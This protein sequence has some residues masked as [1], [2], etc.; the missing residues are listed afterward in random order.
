MLAE[1]GVSESHFKKYFPVGGGDPTPD[2]LIDRCTFFIITSC[3]VATFQGHLSHPLFGWNP[4]LKNLL[5]TPTFAMP[6]FDAPRIFKTQTKGTD[7][8]IFSIY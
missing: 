4:L 7:N 5:T 6:I 3:F 2:N 1:N 8:L